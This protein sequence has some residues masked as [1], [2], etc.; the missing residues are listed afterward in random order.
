MRFLHRYLRSGD[1]G[2]IYQN[3]LFVCGRLK[4]LIIVRGRNH[5]P[6]DLERCVEGADSLLRPGCTA[7]FSVSVAGTEQ[8]VLVAEVRGHFLVVILPKPH[9]VVCELNLCWLVTSNR[10]GIQRK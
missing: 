3:E 6:Q 1:L 4:D 10:F 2:F 5:Y 7:A 9:C 8:A